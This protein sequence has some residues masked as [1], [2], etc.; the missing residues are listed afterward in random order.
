MP[1]D[2]STGAGTH[3]ASHSLTRSGVVL[4][5]RAGRSRAARG[6]RSSC[7]CC[8]AM[9]R[10]PRSKAQTPLVN[11][12]HRLCCELLRNWERGIPGVVFGD[13]AS[14]SPKPIK[15][16]EHILGRESKGPSLGNA[17]YSDAEQPRSHS[18]Q[19]QGTGQEAKPRR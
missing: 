18:P 10:A 5:G 16:V 19:P 17:K 13:F 1:S 11:R 3:P 14:D 12:S 7:W 9:P 8:S 4:L 2:D 15:A 6:T